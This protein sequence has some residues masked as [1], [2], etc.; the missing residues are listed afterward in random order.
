MGLLGLLQRLLVATVS[1]RGKGKSYSQHSSG[2]SRR[3]WANCLHSRFEELLPNHLSGA[4]DN[5]GPAKKSIIT[6]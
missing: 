1:S 2:N 3:F 5:P 6:S 4:S